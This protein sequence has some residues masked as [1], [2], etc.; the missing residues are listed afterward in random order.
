ML[1]SALGPGRESAGPALGS[2]AQ[3]GH[4]AVPEAGVL[5]GQDI[6][7]AEAL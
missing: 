3:P 6:Q 2:L 7:A 4:G 5:Q 1:P